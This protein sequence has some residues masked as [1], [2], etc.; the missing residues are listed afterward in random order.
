MVAYRKR[1]LK[2][3]H[4]VSKREI[5]SALSPCMD[6]R[7]SP[8]VRLEWWSAFS[9]KSS[10]LQHERKKKVCHELLWVW[11]GVAA[12]NQFQYFLILKKQTKQPKNQTAKPPLLLIEISWSKGLR[13]GDRRKGDLEMGY[14]YLLSGL[15]RCPH[16]PRYFTSLSN[17]TNQLIPVLAILLLILLKA[18]NA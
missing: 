1:S 9:Y 5:D 17:H 14:I 15:D 16:F 11:S 6:V 18:V 12:W 10:T 2:G 8:Q 13:T 7:L 4:S 3:A